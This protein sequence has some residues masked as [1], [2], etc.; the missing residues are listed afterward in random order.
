MIEE[1]KKDS[2]IRCRIEKSIHEEFKGICKAHAINPSELIRQWIIA[3]IEKQ[4]K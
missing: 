4:H 2:V 1:P 3:Y